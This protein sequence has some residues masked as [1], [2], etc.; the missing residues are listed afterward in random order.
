MVD[1]LNQ[2]NHPKLKVLYIDHTIY[3]SGAAISLG[4]LIK[5]LSSWVDSYFILRTYSEVE[6]IIGAAGRPVYFER[7]MPQFMT[8]LYSPQYSP[9]LFGW[10]VVKIPLAFIK[11]LLIIKKWNIQI[12]HLNESTIFPYVFICHLL[13]MPVVMHARTA[14]AQRPI[15]EYF[16]S[17]IGKLKRVAIIAIDEETKLSLPAT[18]QHII[19]IIYNPID[20]G[21]EPSEEQIVAMRKSWGCSPGDVVIGQLA[22]LHASKG[23][24]KILE[25]AAILCSE[26]QNVYFILAG[27]DRPG[28]GEGPKLREAIAERGLKDRVV[29]PGYI[30]ELST[31]YGALDIALCLFGEGLGGVGRAAFEAA[32]AGKPL[33]ATLPDPDKSETVKNNVTGLV[34][35]PNDDAA[36]LDAFRKL[37]EN[38][39]KRKEF[40]ERA[41]IEIGNRHTPSVAAS[42]VFSIYKSFV[43]P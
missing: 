32:V 27:D 3:K 6:E 19:Q 30:S 16:L 9:I 42:Q 23:I 22:S 13:K 39:A 31:V 12:V 37:I 25:Y 18:C 5:N 20:L 26:Y 35:K 8:T 38:E 34:Y 1:Y 14:T 43:H 40:G 21:P 33:I 2:E 29:L 4:T 10:H 7:F 24:W 17:K 11:I 36:I 28:I 15:E 41:K